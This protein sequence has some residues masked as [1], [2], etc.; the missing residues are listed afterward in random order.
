M[1]RHLRRF[2]SNALALFVASAL[3]A[4][5]SS[6]SNT[7]PSPGSGLGSNSN[8][9]VHTVTGGSVGRA[10]VGGSLY[11]A[12][13]IGQSVTVYARHENGN[14]TPIRTI[15]G[16][17]TELSSPAFTA[18]DSDKN[19]YVTNGTVEASF[20][21]VYAARAN[22]DV[23]PIRTI[24]GPNSGLDNPAGIALDGD[25]D[26]YVLNSTTAGVS[27]PSITVYASGTNGNVTPIRTIS[28]SKTGL[29]V[30]EGIAVDE[31][32]EVYVANAQVCPRGHCIGTDQVTVYAA[33]ANGNVEPIRKI[34]G[35][36]TLLSLPEGIALDGENNVYVGNL[37]HAQ[38][39]VTVYAAGASGNVA[40]IR[41]IAGSKTGLAYPKGIA[42]DAGGHIYV[43]NS[44]N[45][46][47]VTVYSPGANG[48]VNPTRI[49]RGAKTGLNGPLGAAFR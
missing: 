1:K 40:P 5:C 14:V 15:S 33:G 36:N 22:G 47:S 4:G 37:N 45:D 17:N 20:V 25:N 49:I 9:A 6:T 24:S 21:T 18:L 27:T 13:S 42:L 46:I 7:T 43:V 30:V 28:G 8:W 38:F 29:G 35:S 10:T 16:P 3:L 26:S 11:V 19:L 34:V 2:V 12:N 23:T 31:N 32:A 41:T 48:N 44:L 39:S